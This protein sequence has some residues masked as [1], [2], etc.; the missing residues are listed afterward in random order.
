MIK[1]IKPLKELIIKK[2]NESLEEIQIREDLEIVFLERCKHCLVYYRNEFGHLCR[3][4]KEN[5]ETVDEELDKFIMYKNQI[6]PRLPRVMH[7]ALEDLRNSVSVVSAYAYFRRHV[8]QYQ[9]EEWV[10]YREYMIIPFVYNR[11]MDEQFIQCPTV[12]EAVQRVKKEIEELKRNEELFNYYY[13]EINVL[14]GNV[15]QEIVAEATEIALE[16]DLKTITRKEVEQLVQ[17]EIAEH[18]VEMES[19]ASKRLQLIGMAAIKMIET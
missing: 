19:K 2:I 17:C 7:Y 14:N 15:A 13:G 10:R 11:L 9:R 4:R 5:A 6:E 18:S 8:P 1:I 3:W 12:K 16:M